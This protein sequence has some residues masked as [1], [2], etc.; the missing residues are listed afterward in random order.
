MYYY[1]MNHYFIG[2]VLIQND[3]KKLNNAQSF[4][5]RKIPTVGKIFNFN[6]KFAYLGYM[7]E[8]TMMELQSKISNVFETLT[9]TL[10]PQECTYTKYGIT[11]LKTTKKSISILY[12]NSK[13]SD[14]IV[15]YLRSYTN[16]LTGDESDFYPHISLLRID[17]NDVN[18]VMKEDDKGKN[19][20]EKTFLPKPNTF[21]VDSID[22]I[23]GTPIVKRMGQP[24]KYDDMD[25]KVINRY[26]LRG[27]L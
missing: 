11:G 7:N 10:G 1:I 26:M 13:I 15:P 17:A 3:A 20:L 22:I 8:Q 4:L 6:T 12:E 5:G 18:E 19:I 2:K 9:D 23:K 25:M 24:S 27:N 16:Q 14:V 21:T